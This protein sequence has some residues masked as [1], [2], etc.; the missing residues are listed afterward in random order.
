MQGIIA[1]L[2]KPRLLLQIGLA[3]VFL[4]AAIASFVNPNEWIGY[5]PPF[6]TKIVEPKMA[7]DFF[8]VL[9]I[10]L[11]GWLLSGVYVRWAALASAAMLGGIIVFNL[12][13]FDIAFRDVGLLL[14][15][16]A[17]ACYDD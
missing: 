4:Y 6:M 12:Q 10:G 2:K 9:Q 16:L 15:A 13:L 1:A 11:A 8:S 5:L 14:A 3:F 17:L 7:L